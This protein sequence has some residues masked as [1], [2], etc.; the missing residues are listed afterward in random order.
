MEM[1][2]LTIQ[3]DAELKKNMEDLCDQLGMSLTSVFMIFA[4]AFVMEKGFP[5]PV[6]IQEEYIAREKMLADT[7]ELLTDFQSDYKKMSE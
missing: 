1:T 4:N 2:E 5:F 7:E 6:K 3:I